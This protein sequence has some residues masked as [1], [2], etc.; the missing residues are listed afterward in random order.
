M[1]NI[2]IP[3]LILSI[4]LTSFFLK[5]KIF[6]KS[7][8]DIS[9][10]DK[11]S[12]Q[13]SDTHPLDDKFSARSGAIG[14]YVISD[15]HKNL[16]D[17]IVASPLIDGVF[18]RSYWKTF[19][20]EEGKYDWSFMDEL[21]DRAIKYNKK[22]SLGIAAGNGQPDWIY[23]KD[24]PFLHFV[25]LPKE[26][27]GKFVADI[28]L[29][30]FWNQ[31]YI[32]YW[33]SFIAAVANH[34]KSKPQYWNTLSMI[35]VT[36]F[37]RWNSD[38]FRIPGQR[39]IENE[40]AKSTDAIKIWKENGYRPSLVINAFKQ[41]VDSFAMFFPDKQL[42]LPIITGGKGFPALD[43][44]GK[45]TDDPKDDKVTETILNYMTSKFGKQ[46]MAM[47][48]ALQ[49]NPKNNSIS[50]LVVDQYKKGA[51]IG[52]QL[53]QACYKFPPCLKDNTPCDN[54]AFY[55]VFDNGISQGALYFELYP[56]NIKA[57]PEALKKS[58]KIIKEKN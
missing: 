30:V 37:N 9:I 56:D 16:E 51:S 4:V 45:E 46:F 54:N 21:F 27:K 32:Q 49:D 7:S 24:I 22:V 2:I 48:E 29:P 43:E 50:F 57:Y 33:T 44:N 23:E 18:Q 5:E 38:E 35:K 1:K 15:Y 58:Q 8:Q 13:A 12:N 47:Y 39:N 42:C 11:I 25:E 10:A 17:K 31:K 53:C 3:F 41:V 6:R 14:L 28:K 36:G 26:G 52:Y 34:L 40:N 20:P 55:K 19:E